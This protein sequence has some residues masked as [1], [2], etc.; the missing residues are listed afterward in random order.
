[1]LSNR[2]NAFVSDRLQECLFDTYLAVEYE[3]GEALAICDTYTAD[4]RDSHQEIL[5]SLNIRAYLVVPLFQGD[6]LWGLLCIYQ[7]LHPRQWKKAEI[8]FMQKIAT[9]LGIALQQAQL[10]EQEKQQKIL[11]NQQNQH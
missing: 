7:S 6:R 11:L 5:S 9:Q 8:E 1:M 10:L 4:L 3:E 2:D